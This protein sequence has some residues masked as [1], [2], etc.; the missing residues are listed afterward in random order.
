MWNPCALEAGLRVL[1]RHGQHDWRMAEVIASVNLCWQG[2][3]MCS[4]TW[5]DMLH[6][7]S[8][9]VIE[10]RGS[11]WSAADPQDCR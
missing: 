11:C 3:G 5:L 2:L 1:R 10:L 6:A 4:G 9:G 7:T 8:S